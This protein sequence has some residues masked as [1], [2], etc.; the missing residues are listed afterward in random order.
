M[1]E[2]PEKKV[3]FIVEVAFDPVKTDAIETRRD[4]NPWLDWP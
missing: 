1:R 4:R 2:H 3:A